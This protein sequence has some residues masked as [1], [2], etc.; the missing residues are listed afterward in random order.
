MNRKANDGKPLSRN[1]SFDL[2]G[3]RFVH[4]TLV[5]PFQ[6]PF[7]STIHRTRSAMTVSETRSVLGV[8]SH[9][10]SSLQIIEQVRIETRS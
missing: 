5:P 7:T 8:R 1:E 9:R 6:V 4:H 3:V 10:S 2:F